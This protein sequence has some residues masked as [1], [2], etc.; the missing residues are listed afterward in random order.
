MVNYFSSFNLLLN[1]ENTN[2]ALI[3]LWTDRIDRIAYELKE[4]FL[5]RLR[6]KVSPNQVL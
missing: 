4:S 5:M 6:N 1:P 3:K 2:Q